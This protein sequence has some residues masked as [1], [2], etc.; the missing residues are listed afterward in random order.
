[1]QQK[2]DPAYGANDAGR[3]QDGQVKGTKKIIPF[4]G[5]NVKRDA[6]DNRK[7]ILVSENR[8]VHEQAALALAG[9]AEAGLDV[10]LEDGNPVRVRKPDGAGVRIEQLD[11]NSLRHEMSKACNF[12]KFKYDD[13]EG[14]YKEKPMR[15]APL[16]IVKDALGSPENLLP[17]IEGILSH[18]TISESGRVVSGYGYNPETK[19][20]IDAP[21]EILKAAENIPVTPTEGEIEEAVKTINEVITDFPFKSES[22]KA[23]YFAMLLTLL[24]LPMIN[25]SIPMFL[26]LAAAPGTGKSLTADTAIRIKTGKTATPTALPDNDEELK[27]TLHSLFL[28]GAEYVLFDNVNGKIKSSVLPAVAT[29]RRLNSRILGV[30]KMADAACNAVMIFTANNPDLSRENARRLVPIG[31]ASDFENPSERTGFKHPD[32]NQY[33]TDNRPG[34]IRAALVMVRAWFADECDCSGV[35]TLPSFENWSKTIGGILKSCGVKGFLENVGDFFSTADMDAENIGG[36][37]RAWYTEKGSFPVT[38]KDILPIAKDFG[39][40]SDSLHSEGSQVKSLGRILK[41]K[42]DIVFSGVKI[43]RGTQKCGIQTWKA[44]KVQEVS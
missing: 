33:V 9:I 18:P 7:K 14:K 15:S 5:D 1:M 25:S 13:D 24:F 16:D 2:N 26:V 35:K 31:L 19:L 30:N 39:L 22:D 6:D 20:Y 29:S 4:N 11:A 8:P 3:K 37:V 27:K 42:Q 10:Y 40:I 12:F 44:S 38:A 17:A 43:T 32:L 41:R 21:E 34:L 36:F 28:S 23:G